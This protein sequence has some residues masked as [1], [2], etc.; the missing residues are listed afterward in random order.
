MVV[1][2]FRTGMLKYE[3][4]YISGTF[5]VTAEVANRDM[6]RLQI[7]TAEV[8]NR[9]RGCKSGHGSLPNHRLNE[10]CCA[11]AI[12]VVINNDVRITGDEGNVFE[13]PCPT[14][15]TCWKHFWNKGKK[16]VT[17]NHIRKLQQLSNKVRAVVALGEC[18]QCNRTGPASLGGPHLTNY[19]LYN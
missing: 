1:E 17:Q 4:L 16:S 14:I 19:A 11:F 10:H 12:T 2:N 3:T 9:D 5:Q 13:N 15:R 7:G 18:E 6:P 8:A